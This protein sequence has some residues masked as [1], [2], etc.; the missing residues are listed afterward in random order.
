MMQRILIVEDNPDLL[1][2]LQEVFS[3]DYEV[4]TAT[5]GEEGVRKAL[6]HRPDLILMDLQLPRMSG[7]D[8]GLMIKGELGA[9]AAPIL[10]L[11]ALAPEVVQESVL[12]SGCCDA[13]LSKP[14]SLDDIRDK[15]RELIGAPPPR[16]TA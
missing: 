6:K 12:P 14:A 16:E 11:T 10:A 7:M 13:F 5:A 3:T 15:V 1:E 2:I 4:L 9:S 8:A